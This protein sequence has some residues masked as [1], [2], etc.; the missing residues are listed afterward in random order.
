M[1]V[2][3][4]KLGIARSQIRSYGSQP[5]IYKLEIESYGVDFGKRKARPGGSAAISG[6]RPVGA[7]SPCE[8][9][10]FDPGVLFVIAKRP[11]SGRAAACRSWQR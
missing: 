2:I 8:T 10:R 7:V 3:K 9:A 4:T 1:A 6:A 5:G 11:V